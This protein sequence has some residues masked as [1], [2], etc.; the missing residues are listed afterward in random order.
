[1]IFSE[2]QN[3]LVG[4]D[5][6]DQFTYKLQE[7]IENNSKVISFTGNIYDIIKKNS[8][9]ILKVTN[10][11]PLAFKIFNAEISVSLLLFQEL[12]VQLDSKRSNEACFLLSVH[13]IISNTPILDSDVHSNGESDED[14]TSYLTLNSDQTL[15]VLRGSLI[16]YYVYETLDYDN[17]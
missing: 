13:K 7:T 12:K 8:F 6:L 17:D 11:N 5:T 2:K 1:M 3:A 10:S 4:W 16:N 15:I 9:Y 14:A